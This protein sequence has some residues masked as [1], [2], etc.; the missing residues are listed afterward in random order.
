MSLLHTELNLKAMKVRNNVY[1]V[2][3]QLMKPSKK[4][5]EGIHSKNY[6]QS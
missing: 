1:L 5:E 6:E 2:K 3:E 4:L